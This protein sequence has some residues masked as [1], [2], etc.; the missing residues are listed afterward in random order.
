MAREPIEAQHGPAPRARHNTRGAKPIYPWRE[1]RPGSW[2]KF[3]VGYN[4]N[5]A[6]VAASQAGAALGMHFRI[7]TCVADDR[8]ICMRVD[9]LPDHVRWPKMPLD[10]DTLQPI[11]PKLRIGDYETAP[12]PR[13]GTVTEYDEEG[14]ETDVI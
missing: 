9:G 6:R 1:L 13:A 11:R 7:Y 8:L 2:F 12:E 14:R 4:P 10:P 5:T 3:P